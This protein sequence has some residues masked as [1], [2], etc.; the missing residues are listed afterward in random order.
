M[1]SNEIEY[2]LVKNE[3]GCTAGVSKFRQAGQPDSLK[4]RKGL[5]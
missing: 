3:C 4:K 1:N 2:R 5:F